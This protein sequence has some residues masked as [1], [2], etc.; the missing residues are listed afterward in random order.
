MFCFPKEI[1]L[2]R[3]EREKKLGSNF[4]SSSPGEGK[5]APVNLSKVKLVSPSLS[6]S[7]FIS[8]T[9]QHYY[10]FS[11]YCI[12]RR[13]KIW[14]KKRR[15][16]ANC[17]IPSPNR[18]SFSSSSARSPSYHKKGL[19]LA[20]APS[21]PLPGSADLLVSQLFYAQFSFP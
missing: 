14:E 10:S 19:V 7:F 15:K 17:R 8:W 12:F 13:E 11:S 4:S 1:S 16:R 18:M 20:L 21:L 3:K 9:P 2:S 6:H 5:N